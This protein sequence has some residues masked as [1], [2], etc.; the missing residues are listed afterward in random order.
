MATATLTSTTF[1]DTVRNP[2]VTVRAIRRRE[3]ELTGARAH[4]L[5][6]ATAVHP[7]PIK[8]ALGCAAWFVFISWALF[9][10][11]DW[12]TVL[13]VA[14]VTIIFAMYLGGLTWGAAMSPDVT[15]ER[16]ASRTFQEFL[17]GDVD[18]ATGLISGR[19]AMVQ[20]IVLP[21]TLAVGGT[22]IALIWV[23]IR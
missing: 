21:L 12:D 6:A 22:A 18:I 15:P 5:A 4:A 10:S 16:K 17:D 14:V 3:Q 11:A 7:A 1:L 8:I 9:A 2:S 20:I 19:E 23:F 13:P